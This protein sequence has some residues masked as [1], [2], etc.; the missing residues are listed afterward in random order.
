MSYISKKNQEAIDYF[1]SLCDFKDERDICSKQDQ[2]LYSTTNWCGLSSIQGVRL[3]SVMQKTITLKGNIY[4]RENL[5][6]IMEAV[7]REKLEYKKANI[8]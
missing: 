8:L 3:T 2:Y 1:C 5:N 4:L 6:G 7:E